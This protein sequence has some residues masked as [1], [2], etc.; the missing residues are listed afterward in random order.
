MKDFNTYRNLFESATYNK[1][2]ENV[3]YD[4]IDEL[5][6]HIRKLSAIKERHANDLI[7][8]LFDYTD[9]DNFEDAEEADPLY[10]Q[11]VLDQIFAMSPDTVDIEEQ[12]ISEGMAV[13]IINNRGKFKVIGAHN[14]QPIY[15][16]NKKLVFDTYDQAKAYVDKSSGL[17]Y[18]KNLDETCGHC[19][20]EDSD[21]VKMARQQLFKI[22]KD[23]AK[24]HNLLDCDEKLKAWHQSLITSSSDDI[25][26]VYQSLS[27]AYKTDTVCESS[28]SLKGM[29]VF[30]SD[31]DGKFGDVE[32]YYDS[33]G[34]IEVSCDHFRHLYQFKPSEYEVKDG[35]IV[36]KDVEYYS[37][38]ND[39]R[40]YEISSI[41]ESSQSRSIH[42]ELKKLGVKIDNH[43]TDLYVEKTPAVLKLLKDFPI[44]KKN[45]SIFVDQRTKKDMIEIPFAFEKDLKESSNKNLARE[46]HYTKFEEDLQKLMV[47]H[48]AKADQISDEFHSPAHKH[49]LVKIAKRFISQYK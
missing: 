17:E 24:L 35:I 26:A 15:D 36:L 33:C 8:E 1:I 32:N 43:F 27:Y 23:A 41:V 38:A 11:S 20:N 4:K 25:G 14:R 3:D 49:D 9:T 6:D 42:R 34:S 39:N 10:Y 31:L 2:S 16:G 44:H 7:E 18:E 21:D 29:R 28:G 37:D 47:K 5:E 40:A 30:Y 19:D 22:A 46:R 48:F 13:N 45:A 12:I